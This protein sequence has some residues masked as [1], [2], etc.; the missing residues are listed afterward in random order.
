MKYIEILENQYFKAFLDKSNDLIRVIWFPE[1]E[2]GTAKEFIELNNSL[3]R[4]IKV[5]RLFSDLR[6]FNFPIVPHL[7]LDIVKYT[8]KTLIEAGV[9]K[10]AILIPNDIFTMVSVSQTIDEIEDNIGFQIDFFEDE[11]KAT[12]WILN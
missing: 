1:S 4:A 8:S 2:H 3:F 11:K 5:K 7:Q 10:I 9:E 12:E 6:E